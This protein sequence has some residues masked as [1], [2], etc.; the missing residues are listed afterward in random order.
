LIDFA[1]NG[2]EQDYSKFVNHP[3]WKERFGDVPE[4]DVRFKWTGF[5]ETIADA[6]RPYKINRKPLIDFVSKLADKY[7]LAYIKDKGL[8]D[9][10]PFTLM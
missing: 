3:F 6:L 8:E 4:E 2:K 5:Y 7:E 10:D 1:F 9:I